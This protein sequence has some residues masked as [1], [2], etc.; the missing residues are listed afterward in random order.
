M[1]KLGLFGFFVII[2]SL[3]FSQIYH[4]VSIS[5]LFDLPAFLIVFGGTCGAVLVQSSAKQLTHALRLLPQVFFSPPL[6][7]H[8]QSLLIQKWSDKSRKLGLLSL[9]PN[10]NESLDEFTSKALSML[11]DGCEP[12][13]LQEILQ[14]DIDLESEHY[15]RSAQIY[16]SMGG[17]SPTIGIIGAVMGL[18]QAMGYLSEPD[19]LGAG[20]AVAFVATIYGVGF[21][22]FIFLPIA[23]KIRLYYQYIALYKEMTLIGLL[24]IAHGENSLLL[25]RRLSGY[26]DRGSY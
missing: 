12:L 16:E 10:A 25:E 4:G 2:A 3:L 5:G 21:A 14:Q 6:P 17:Y 11:V 22:N 13:V 20:I 26:L 23:N 7:L 18:I 19:K 9:E 1:N 8:K 15:E 24:A